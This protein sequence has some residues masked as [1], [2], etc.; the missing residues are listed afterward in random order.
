M[1]DK[2]VLHQVALI[3]VFGIL[4]MWRLL[5]KFWGPDVVVLWWWLGGMLGFLMVFGDRLIYTL[6]S[7]PSEILS[8]KFKD[9]MRGGRLVEGMRALL[10][11]RYEQKELAMRNVLFLVVWIV[12]AFFSATS[13]ANRFAT[14]LMLGV[15]THLI[16]DFLYDFFWG[17]ER[18]DYWFWQIKRDIDESEKRWVVGLATL[19]YILLA[20]SL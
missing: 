15:G 19:F 20:F 13:V 7:K 8:I 10:H 14:G 4:T 18:F 3:G 1:K 2:L 16:F 5:T 12:M 11:E 9:L 17:R 6:V